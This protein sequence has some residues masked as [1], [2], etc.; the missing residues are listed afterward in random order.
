MKY[1]FKHLI[2]KILL[3]II[4]KERLIN[5]LN[6]DLKNSKSILRIFT[7]Y[8]YFKSLI[9]DI[10]INMNEEP[11]PWYTYPA[12]EYISQLELKEKTVFEWGCGN[13]S[14]FFANKAKEVIS[15]EDNLEW[16]NKIKRSKPDNLT[17][18]Y[19][20]DNEYVELISSLN[21]KFDIIVI[22]ANRRMECSKIA[23]RYLIPG[24]IVILDNS[25]WYTKSAKTI[26]ENNFIQVDFYGFGPLNNYTWTTSLFF[27]RDFN[28]KAKNNI[29]PISVIGGLTQTNE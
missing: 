26:R 3:K 13:S 12:I 15:I 22:D 11:L 10:P 6:L 28:F 25:D 8:G 21:R 2:I 1:F 23:S 4:N 24:G 17:L 20:T 29:Q 19:A 27:S 16:Y 14:L 9:N 5:L 18:I 7:E